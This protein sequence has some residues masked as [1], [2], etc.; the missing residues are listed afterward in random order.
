MLIPYPANVDKMVALLPVLANGGWDL[1][2]EFKGLKAL[3]QL[4]TPDS[5]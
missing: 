3:T 4:V 2:R 1:I 5:R